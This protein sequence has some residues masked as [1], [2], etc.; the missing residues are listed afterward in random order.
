MA[1][2]KKIETLPEDVVVAEDRHRYEAQVKSWTRDCYGFLP[3]VEYK[4]KSNGRIDWR[5]MIPNQYLVPNRDKFPP[6]TD[7][8]ALKTEE[9]D[10]KQ[11]LVLLHGFKYILDIRGCKSIIYKIAEASAGF[12]AVT[13]KLTLIPNYETPT[14]VIYS[15]EGDSHHENTNSWAQSF[16]TCIAGNRAFVRA[17][18]NALGI[19]ITGFDEVGPDKEEEKKT[20]PSI[21]NPV[22]ILQ[23]TLENS[24][25]SFE[26]FK[27]NMIKRGLVKEDFSD[28]SKFPTEHIYEA[29]TIIQKAVQKATPNNG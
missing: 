28:I 23:S 15:G 27:A 9:L 20:T 6:G 8:K 18:R 24:G 19:E 16:T 11:L 21:N 22:S 12:S 7:L 4:F 17:T 29:V 2:P 10:D 3:G 25:I 5:A 14:E 26:K 13:C 1:K